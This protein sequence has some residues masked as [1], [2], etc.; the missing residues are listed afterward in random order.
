MHEIRT[1]SGARS[2]VLLLDA[3]IRN[4]VGEAETILDGCDAAPTMFGLASAWIS[5]AEHAG[6]DARELLESMRSQVF[7]GAR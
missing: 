2:T 5:L 6:L 1:Q 4:D 3:L 7:G